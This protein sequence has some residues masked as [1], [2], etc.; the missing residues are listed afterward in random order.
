LFRPAIAAI[1]VCP[2][3]ANVWGGALCLVA[4]GLVYFYL[5]FKRGKK[6]RIICIFFIK[7]IKN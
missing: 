6:I 7:L 1:A 3:V 4:I 2:T 5:T